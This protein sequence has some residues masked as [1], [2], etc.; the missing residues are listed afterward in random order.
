M[1]II[2]ICL[3]S[4]YFS[5]KKITNKKLSLYISIQI[6]ILNFLMIYLDS[7][8]YAYYPDY[9]QAEQILHSSEHKS[10]MKKQTVKLVHDI[11]ITSG[12]SFSLSK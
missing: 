11:D 6:I 4:L 10:Q 9:N 1:V 7:H 2:L 5:L 8:R 12:N 3:N